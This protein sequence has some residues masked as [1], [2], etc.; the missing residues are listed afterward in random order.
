[1][2]TR[3]ALFAAAAALVLIGAGCGKAAAP[4]PP[5]VN[6]QAV[7]KPSSPGLPRM[8]AQPLDEDDHLDAAL[9][10]LDTVE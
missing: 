1:M 5:P 2:K 8:T 3:F 10:D 9:K 7:E 4:F 6:Q